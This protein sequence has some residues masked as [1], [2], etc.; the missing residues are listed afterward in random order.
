MNDWKPKRTLR[1][2]LRARLPELAKEYF[3]AGSLA[4]TPGT[5]WDEMHQFR[6]ST[7]RFRYTLEIF[8]PAYGPGLA[9]RI[10]SLKQVQ[11]FLGNINDCI[12]TA[13]ILDTLPGTDPLKAKLAAKADRITKQLRLFW[14]EQFAALGKLPNWRAYLMR[15]ACQPRRAT[16]KRIA[17]APAHA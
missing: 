9:Q 11:G 5:S 17:S 6:L 7:K 3:A 12:V 1:E 10:E 16:R 14:A 4:L 2:N 8:R 13:N 15:Y